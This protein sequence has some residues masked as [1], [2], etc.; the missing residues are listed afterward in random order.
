MLV[1]RYTG[2]SWRLYWVNVATGQDSALAAPPFGTNDVFPQK[3]PVGPLVAFVRQSKARPGYDSLMVLNLETRSVRA[4]VIDQFVYRPLWDNLG[5]RILFAGG[6]TGGERILIFEMP[7]GPTKITA[8]KFAAPNLSSVLKYAWSPDNSKIAYEVYSLGEPRIAVGVVPRNQPAQLTVD[9]H[10]LTTGALL[11]R[12]CGT[13][14]KKDTEYS[15]MFSPDGQRVLFA[16]NFLIGEAPVAGG[17]PSLVDRAYS[18]RCDEYGAWA[19]SG[20]AL[21][22]EASAEGGAQLWIRR[23][24]DANAIQL[25]A[26]PKGIARY[27][28]AWSPDSKTLAVME[29]VPF[30]ADS[31]TQRVS[32]VRGF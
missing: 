2:G 10:L 23:T 15:P 24:G 16:S 14:V 18:V 22:I 28:A 25:T 6:A 5:E 12:D 3:S 31:T 17:A 20:H 9:S 29:R 19:P 27:F 8:D 11:P 30:G 7:D 26:F 32:L 1:P 21:A 13:Q 4:L